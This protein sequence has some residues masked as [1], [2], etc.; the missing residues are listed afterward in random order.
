MIDLREFVDILSLLL[1]AASKDT[2]PIYAQY[3]KSDGESLITCNNKSFIKINYE[4]PF[5][6]CVNIYI[7]YSILKK[8]VDTGVDTLLH[9]EGGKL[10]VTALQEKH[11]IQIIKT[12][13]YPDLTINLSDR[14]YDLSDSLKSKIEFA[15]KFVGKD[16]LSP[17]YLDKDVLMAT[18]SHRAYSAP[19][20]STLVDLPISLTKDIISFLTSPITEVSIRSDNKGNTIILFNLG[21]GIFTAESLDF[22]PKDKILETIKTSRE[23][24]T[25][26][27]N[28]AGLAYAIEAV[29]PMFFG[30]SLSHIELYN[31]ENVLRVRAESGVNGESDVELKSS[32]K[33]EF[34]MLLDP[35]YIKS[36]PISFDAYIN[37]KN[38]SKL[39]LNNGEYE[40]I[41]LMGAVA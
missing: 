2:Y 39:Y 10:I 30:E 14:Y 28:V 38:T 15:T 12:L 32:L 25:L 21:Y 18:D 24:T 20:A 41:V 29:T 36:I 40:E 1:K 22:Y 7:L 26:W 11:N 17:V 9:V 35:R 23:E 31:K 5:L 33:E 8:C 6:G 34:T 16:M 4:A 27:C 3:V 13:P 37:P 19:S